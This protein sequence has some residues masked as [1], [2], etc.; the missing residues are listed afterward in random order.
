METVALKERKEKDSDEQYLR[1]VGTRLRVQLRR[2][3]ESQFRNGAGQ[4][5]MGKGSL[6]FFMKRVMQLL[7]GGTRQMSDPRRHPNSLVSKRHR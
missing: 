4:R 7:P 3:V 5:W 1:V 6:P 2:L